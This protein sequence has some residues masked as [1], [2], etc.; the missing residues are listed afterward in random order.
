[1]RT[2]EIVQVRSHS[3]SE[4]FLK[5]L[6]SWKVYGTINK[7]RDF[8][9]HFFV[10]REQKEALFSMKKEIRDNQAIYAHLLDF[11]PIHR[12]FVAPEKKSAIDPSAGSK[13]SMPSAGLGLG[14]GGFEPVHAARTL[15]DGRVEITYFAPDAKRVEIAGMGGSMPGRYDLEPQGDG[16]WR[17]LIDD[18][19]PGFHFCVFI[20]DGVLTFSP[21]MPFGYGFSYVMNYFEVPDP[22]EDFYL[23]K[24]VPH[25]A[26]RMELMKSERTGRYRN[27]WVYTPHGYDT[28]DKRYPVMHILHGGGEN[29]AGWFWQGKLNYIADNLI[30]EGKCEEMIIVASSFAAMRELDDGKFINDSFPKVMVDEIVPFIDAN[31]RTIADRNHRAMAGLSAGGSMARQI[32]HGFPETF[33]NLGQ[34]SCGAGFSVTGISTVENKLF[35]GPMGSHP[36]EMTEKYQKLFSSPESYNKTMDLTFITCGTDDPRHQYTEP[37]VKELRDMGFNVEYSCYP[38]HHEWDVWRYSARDYMIRLFRK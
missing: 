33:A 17:V 2:A 24:D 31:Y 34:F 20:V 35:P 30:A 21:T 14:T 32:A 11:D 19:G 27:L 10:N 37:Q 26:I 25:G 13:V 28:S 9:V 16:Y 8:P 29:E 23:L 22:N 12:K 1:M 36:A 4:H 5:D 7:R 18:V 38:G 3:Y 6:K 15:D